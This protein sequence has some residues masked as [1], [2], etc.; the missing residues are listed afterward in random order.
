LTVS[1]TLNRSQEKIPSP[2]NSL[3]NFTSKISVNG[4]IQVSKKGWAVRIAML[5]AMVLFSTFRFYTG[6]NL[7]DPFIIYSTIAPAITI[8]M[9]VG[10]WC[11]YRSPAKGTAGNN[12]VSVKISKLLQ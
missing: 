8:L 12:L 10:A 6:I 3:K 11:W 2:N 1:P 4:R 7:E 5:A 9:F